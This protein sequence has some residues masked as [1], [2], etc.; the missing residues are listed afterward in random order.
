MNCQTFS[1][2]FSSGALDGEHQGDVGRHHQLRRGVPA[3]LV[4]NEN[5]MSAGIDGEADLLEMLVHGR[6]V[7]V[8]QD[9]AGALALFGAD[10][11]EDVGSHGSL[12]A[13]CR[14]PR[15][16][17]GPAPRDLVLLPY[18]GFVSHQSSISVLAGSLAWMAASSAGKL[19]EWLAPFPRRMI[20]SLARI[21]RRR[22]DEWD[23]GSWY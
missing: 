6:R 21:P 14:R 9:E 12:V 10:G 22:V 1:T 4:E 16:P 17:F 13:W 2:G 5:G 20:A 18:S 7:A 8:G 11:S 15:A 3:G 19:M 23:Q